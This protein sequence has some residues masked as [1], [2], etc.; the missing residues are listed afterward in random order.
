M[1]FGSAIKK[2]ETILFGGP[3]IKSN[4]SEKHIEFFSFVYERGWGESGRAREEIKKHYF[5]GIE[6]E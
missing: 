5:W 2:T 1:E 3:H 4:E 6:C